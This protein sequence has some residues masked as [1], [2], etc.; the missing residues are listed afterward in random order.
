[1]ALHEVIERLS[2]RNDGKE[3]L[4]QG[5]QAPVQVPYYRWQRR[6]D[7]NLDRQPLCGSAGRSCHSN[8]R[9]GT[10]AGRGRPSRHDLRFEL[11]PLSVCEDA[12]AAAW[13]PMVVRRDFGRSFHLGQYAAV[14]GERLRSEEHTSELQSRFELVCRLLLE[15]K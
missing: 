13:P 1:M 4:G 11:Q 14:P 8:L 6:T 2:A 7:E 9:P 12:Q 3:S 10:P 5:L 15:K